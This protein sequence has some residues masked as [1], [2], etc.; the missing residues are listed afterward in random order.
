MFGAIY[1]W[2]LSGWY[3]KE[4]EQVGQVGFTIFI[5]AT[6]S[7]SCPPF[8]IHPFSKGMI[9]EIQNTLV[10]IKVMYANITLLHHIDHVLVPGK[11]T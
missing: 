7:L 11:I 3:I 1:I 5:V 8:S 9:V 10:Y 2:I 6:S 4:T